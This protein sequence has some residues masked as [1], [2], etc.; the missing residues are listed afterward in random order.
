[1]SRDDKH[2]RLE[3]GYIDWT[4][5]FWG[6]IVALVLASLAGIGLW[7]LAQYIWRHATWR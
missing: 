6:F 5:L 3:R 7:E 2:G 4:P 1:M